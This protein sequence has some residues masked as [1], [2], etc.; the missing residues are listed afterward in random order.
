[1]LNFFIVFILFIYLYDGAI[2]YIGRVYVNL[3][4]WHDEKKLL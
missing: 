4:Y 3:S 2:E 1:M